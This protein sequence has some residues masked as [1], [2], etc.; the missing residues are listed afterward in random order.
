MSKI[1]IPAELVELL[2]DGLRSRLAVAAQ[3]VANADGHLDARGHPE[4]YQDPLRRIDDLRA[5][6]ENIGWSNPPSDLHVDLQTH[7][8]ALIEAL[9]EEVRFYAD[10]LREI[11]QDDEQYDTVTRNMGAL[12]ALALT[13]LLRTQAP[14]IPSPN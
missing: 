12:M 7:G 4:R 5:L 11:D 6:L 8:W 10:T 1:L 3:D 13:L 14:A 9:G 2:R